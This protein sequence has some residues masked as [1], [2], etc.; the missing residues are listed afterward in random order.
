MRPQE[1]ICDKSQEAMYPTSYREVKIGRT[2]YCVT[3]VYK[4]E[5]NLKDA[6]EDLIVRRALREALSES[7]SL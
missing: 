3:S 6:L 2:I 7:G 4:G 1:A 5:I